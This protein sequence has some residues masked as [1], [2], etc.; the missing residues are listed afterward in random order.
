MNIKGMDQLTVHFPDLQTLGGRIRVILSFAGI[1]ALVTLFFVW[2]DRVFAEWMPDGEIL[3]MA[4]GF[5]VLSLVFSRKAVYRQKYGDLAYRYAIL[6]FGI[7]GVAI[8]IACIAHLAYM[9]GPLIPEVVWWRPVLNG[10]GW[11]LVVIGAVLWIRTAYTF[12]IDYAGLL[13]VY[14]PEGGTLVRSSIYALIRHP[15]YASALYIGIGLAFISSNWY[16]L[17]VALLLPVGWTGWIR[18]VEEKE[19]IQRFP[20]YL[21]YRR[22]VPAFWAKIGELGKFYGFLIRG[23]PNRG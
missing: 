4:I 19:I 9:P 2:V 22:E 5:L 6:H 23:D 7:P 21:A 13:Y 10:L 1:I 16:A 15:I 11:V 20:D 17:V 12:G 18:L 14:F 8:I 3:I